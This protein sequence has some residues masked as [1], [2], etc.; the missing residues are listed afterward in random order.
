MAINTETNLLILEENIAARLAVMRRRGDC[1][2]YIIFRIEFDDNTI[3][4]R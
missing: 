1:G 4:K 2:R 3:L